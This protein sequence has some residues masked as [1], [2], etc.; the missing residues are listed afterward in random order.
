MHNLAIALKIKGHVVT[1]SDDEIFEPAN[2]KLEYYELLPEKTGWYPSMITQ[3]IDAVILGMHAKQDNPELLR[4]QELNLKIYSFPQFI[5][6]NSKNKTKVVIAGSHGKTTITAMIM[7][8]LRTCRVNFDYLVGAELEG[9]DLMVRVSEEAKVMILEGDE[10]LS[11]PIDPRPKFL[12]YEP[13]ISLITGIAWDHINVF[14]TNENYVSQ[15]KTFIDRLPADSTLIY[16]NGDKVLKKLV[17]ARKSVE[18]IEYD[19]HP[20]RIKE[21]KSYLLVDE[22]EIPV[23][24]IGKHNMQNINGALHVCKKLEIKADDFY[25]SIQ[26]FTGAA[27]RLELLGQNDSTAVFKDFAHAPSKLTATI[28]AVKEQFEGRFLVA[29]IE[30][31]T[32]SSLNKSFIKQYANSMKKADYAIVYIDPHAL[33]A[34]KLEKI[35]ESELRDAFKRDDLVVYYDVEELKDDL[36]NRDWENYNLLLMSSGNFNNLQLL[37]LTNFVLNKSK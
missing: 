10:Y 16:F 21:N 3:E 26:S 6:E 5:S 35:S 33:E 12:W 11:S 14:P 9:F 29:C 22:K 24:V 23:S 32:F 37:D 15:F 20:S 19:E 34:K 2:E 36:Q 18:V 1:G 17:E 30:L 31:H 4:A 25:E 27:K 7:H 8:V 13:E 28:S